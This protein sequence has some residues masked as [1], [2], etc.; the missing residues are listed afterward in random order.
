MWKGQAL[1]IRPENRTCVYLGL[2]NTPRIRSNSIASEQKTIYRR[3]VTFNER[4]FSAEARHQNTAI[5]RTHHSRARLSDLPETEEG[6]LPT[7]DTGQDLIG[8]TFTDEETFD[9]I[10]LELQDGNQL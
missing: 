9:V 7:I 4:S 8:C 3:N 10:S 2:P 6:L 5:E 1:Q